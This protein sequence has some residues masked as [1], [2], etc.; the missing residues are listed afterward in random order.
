[1]K[2]LLKR[3]FTADCGVVNAADF[4]RTTRRCTT[5]SLNRVIDDSEVITPND[6]VEAADFGQAVAAAFSR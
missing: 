2:K 4:T 5:P 1:M 6:P 3:F